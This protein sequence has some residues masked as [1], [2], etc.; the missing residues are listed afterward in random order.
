MKSI[1]YS[2]HKSGEVSIHQKI[3]G[4]KKCTISKDSLNKYHQH[5][6][7]TKKHPWT[8]KICVFLNKHLESVWK[9][10]IK[11][12]TKPEL[13]PNKSLKKESVPMDTPLQVV[14][15]CFPFFF[16]NVGN[17]LLAPQCRCLAIQKS[18]V[19][20]LY[21]GR[22]TKTTSEHVTTSHDSGERPIINTYLIFFMVA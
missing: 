1:P 15:P 21:P 17:W 16:F 22:T 13:Q 4:P 10:G 19:Q 2:P 12:L 20:A 11:Y 5:I 3:L 7:E 18:K 6:L 9:K 14:P 8:V